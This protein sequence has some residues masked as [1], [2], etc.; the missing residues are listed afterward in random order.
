[1]SSE[2]K[3]TS[4]KTDFWAFV[5]FFVVAAAVLSAVKWYGG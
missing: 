1:M 5:L 4:Q 3:P 2:N